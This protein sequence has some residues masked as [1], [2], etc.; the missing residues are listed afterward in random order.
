MNNAE[1]TLVETSQF[2]KL[3]DEELKAFERHFEKSEGC[4]IWKNCASRYGSIRI[5]GALFR[6]NRLSWMVYRGSIPE[7]M[8][9]LHN[10]PGGDN[11]RCV[12]PDH[13]WLGTQHQNILD[14][15][16]KGRAR[17]PMGD[18]SG[19]R[20][21]P[22]SVLRGSRNL[23]AKLTEEQVLKIFNQCNLGANKSRLAKE[24]G[25]SHGLIC[26]ISNGRSWNHVTGLPKK[27]SPSTAIE[28]LVS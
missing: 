21:C 8:F 16:K 7:G 4:W 12:N 15:E 28:S 3:T 14:M 5:R 20:T 23:N 27:R 26:H 17:H 13:L 18:A 24:L 1:T 2:V 6:A 25:V 10:C 19:M 22:E 11:S 9:A